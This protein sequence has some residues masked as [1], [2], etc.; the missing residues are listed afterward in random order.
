MCIPRDVSFSN[1]GGGKV[2]A[3]GLTQVSGPARTVL[4]R[5]QVTMPDGTLDNTFG[6]GRATVVKLTGDRRGGATCR[7]IRKCVSAEDTT[8]PKPSSSQDKVK[9]NKSG[10]TKRNKESLIE[11]HDGKTIVLEGKTATTTRYVS[12]QPAAR[13]CGRTELR[14]L[15]SGA[16]ETVRFTSAG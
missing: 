10:P 6:N 1:D 7:R 2:I 5:R 8:T 12:E 11:E 16:V 15:L 3:I 14:V 13:G 4:V 9:E